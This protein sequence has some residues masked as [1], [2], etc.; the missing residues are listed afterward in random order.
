MSQTPTTCGKIAYA[1]PQEAYAAIQSIRGPN[2]HGKRRTHARAYRCKH[3]G[4]HH[5]TSERER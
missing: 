4:Q 2:H 3:C 1:S 5:I